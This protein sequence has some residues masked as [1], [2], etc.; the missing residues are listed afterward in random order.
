MGFN[1][2]QKFAKKQK[3]HKIACIVALLSGCFGFLELR[4][5]MVK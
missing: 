5:E 2:L 3:V 1:I 4:G